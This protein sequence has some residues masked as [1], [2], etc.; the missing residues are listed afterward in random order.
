MAA[1]DRVLVSLG[2]EGDLD[3]EMPRQKRHLMFGAGE[4]TR[5]NVDTWRDASEAMSSREIAST[6]LQ[7]SGSD[8]RDRKLMTD[9]TRRVSKALRQL[10]KAERVTQGRD[11]V[12]RIVWRMIA[13]LK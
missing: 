1:L 3:A 9:H 8:A 2:Y 4:L 6:I 7:L 10:K 12:G 11:D 13:P 5:G